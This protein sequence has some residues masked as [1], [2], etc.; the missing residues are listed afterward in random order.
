MKKLA[1]GCVIF[2]ALAVVGGTIG[3][4]MVYRM[5]FSCMSCFADLSTSQ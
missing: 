5:V 4:Y 3:S 2:I 1:I